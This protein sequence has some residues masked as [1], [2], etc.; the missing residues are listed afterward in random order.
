MTEQFSQIIEHLEK[1]LVA[2]HVGRVSAAILDD[3]Q[4]EAYGTITPLH[5]LSTITNQGA[6]ALIIQPWDA[7]VLKQI[8][9]AIH[10]SSI[11]VNPVIDGTVVRLNFPP[12]TEEKRLAVVKAVKQKCEE[13]HI[14]VKKV[15]EDMMQELKKQKNDTEISEDEFFSTQKDIQQQ[16]DSANTSIEEHGKRKEAEVMTV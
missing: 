2:L 9:K 12:M 3:I 15:R 13:A 1:E 7:S 16:V 5:Q 11:D 4:I 10:E 6:Q 8:E 14:A